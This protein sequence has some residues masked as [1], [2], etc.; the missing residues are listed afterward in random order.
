[1]YQSFFS[2]AA[3]VCS[4]FWLSEEFC[5]RHYLAGLLLIEAKNSLGQEAAARRLAL[6]TLRDLMAKHELD[7]RYQA[8]V[9]F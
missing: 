5:R 2:A 8:K 1:M 9:N 4:E 7:D 3:D 6:N